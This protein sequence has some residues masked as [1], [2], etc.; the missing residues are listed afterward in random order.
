VGGFRV[1]ADGPALNENQRDQLKD[2]VLDSRIDPPKTAREALN[3]L[4]YISPRHAFRMS[5]SASEPVV[6]VLVCL[7][8]DHLGTVQEGAPSAGGYTR[9]LSK[10]IQ[11]LVES[12]FPDDPFA[13]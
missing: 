13:R 6:D 4:C 5:G 3:S 10:E 9:E 1:V 2:L 12:L 8:C 11:A 7:S